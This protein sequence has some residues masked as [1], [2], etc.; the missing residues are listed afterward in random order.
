MRMRSLLVILLG[1]VLAACTSVEVGDFRNEKPVLDLRT[2]FDG[3]IDAWGIV[4]NRDGT[5]S[6]RFNVVILASWQGDTGTLDET[7]TYSDGRTQKRVWTLTKRGDHTIG[8]AA[9]VVGDAVGET[10]G[11][12][13]R[14]RY[15]LDY[16]RGDGTVHL[17]VDDWMYLM[18]ERT[19]LNR[20]SISKLGF[21]IA[22]V[23]L[24]FRKRD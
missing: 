4:R 3:T 11:N 23:T 7:F 6:Q 17:D 9:D 2:Y 1:L 13:F 21:E 24:S 10:A 20:S 22:Q 5:I 16:P 15:V 19:M 14:F 12:A 8:R 18:D